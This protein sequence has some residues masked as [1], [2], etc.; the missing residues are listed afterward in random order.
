MPTKKENWLRKKENIERKRGVLHASI[1]QEKMLLTISFQ[2]FTLSAPLRSTEAR[3]AE[4][5]LAIAVPGTPL[6]VRLLGRRWRRAALA[7]SDARRGT[8]AG[9][10]RVRVAVIVVGTG[11]AGSSFSSSGNAEAARLRA[12]SFSPARAAVFV[13]CA[14]N[15]AAAVILFVFDEVHLKILARNV[16]VLLGTSSAEAS[17]A[18]S[19][20]GRI[21]SAFAMAAVVRCAVAVPGAKSAVRLLARSGGAFHTEIAFPVSPTPPKSSLLGELVSDLHLEVALET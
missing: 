9:E 17:A 7:G 6:A 15:D 10:S 19:R 13:R 21:L 18:H 1:A 2:F 3:P 14:P 8:G 11:V 20:G 16:Q 4:V 12:L 5:R